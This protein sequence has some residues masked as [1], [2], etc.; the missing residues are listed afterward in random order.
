MNVSF[1]KWKGWDAVK[2]TSGQHTV[3][4]GTSAGPRILSLRCNG[5]ENLLYEDHT[6]FG[7]GAWRMYGGHRFTIAPEND[8]SYYPDNEPCE[9]T[10]EDTA[11]HITAQQRS[12]GLML[13]LV[14][15]ESPEGGFYIDHVLV[16]GGSSDWSGALWAITCVL[17]SHILTG[18]C[19]T[20]AINFW[21]GTDASKW[22]QADGKIGVENG[23][24]RGK[25]GWYSAAPELSAVST[26]GK[27]TITSPDKTV[28]ELCVDNGSNVEIFVCAGW[29][30][31]ETLSEKY[32]VAQGGSVVHR[33]RWQFITREHY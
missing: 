13:S 22:K 24:F 20:K 25:A 16:N 14:I 30:E 21:P 33:Q 11:I 28:P 4:I 6:D 3:V 7:V 29:A 5:G 31:L 19:Q 9:V 18:S 10:M 2:C 23:D 12:N 27:F 8:D 15:S 17:R 1:E 32:I 26:K